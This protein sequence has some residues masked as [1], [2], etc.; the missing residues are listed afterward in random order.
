MKLQKAIILLFIVG[1][2]SLMSFTTGTDAGSYE[3]IIKKSKAEWFGR[4]VGGG[5]EG[6]V[7]IKSG[8]FDVDGMRL[9][10]GE[11]VIDMT[12]MVPTDTKGAD[13]KKLTKHLRG[14]DF[15]N[16]KKYP[17]SKLVIKESESTGEKT[18][19]ITADLTILDQTHEITFDAKTLAKSENFL[20]ASSTITI[21]R[22][23]WGITYKSSLVGD[24]VIRD[25][26]DVKIKIFGKLK[27]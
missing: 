19:T 26:F 11:F 10:S 22:T 15:F 1:A 24:A 3:L 7:D 6:T 27:K 12:T 20:I 8:S 5:H 14:K 2:V 25:N 16:V 18:Y 21:D 17:T 9:T 23:K 4:K 13:T